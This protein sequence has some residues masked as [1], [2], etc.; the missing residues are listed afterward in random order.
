MVSTTCIMKCGK[1]LTTSGVFVK[2]NS[3]LQTGH[4]DQQ[5][6]LSVHLSSLIKSIKLN[7]N[8]NSKI[9]IFACIILLQ[10]AL[11]LITSYS[12]K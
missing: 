12:T 3:N 5:P 11:C 6:F 4:N 10:L 8:S 2:Q 7:M 1:E 9:Q